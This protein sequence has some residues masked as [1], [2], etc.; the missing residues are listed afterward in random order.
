MVIV[1]LAAAVLAA[2][3]LAG[4]SGA[5][6]PSAPQLPSAAP[7]TPAAATSSTAPTPQG[8]PL[9][10][11]QAARLFAR[12]MGPVNRAMGTFQS[13]A[14]TQPPFRQ[15]QAEGAVVIAA[16]HA[17]EN[18]LGAVRWPGQVQSDISDVMTSFEPEEIACTQAQ[19]ETGS[20]AAA[21][22]VSTTNISC[23]EAST[24][25]SVS[26]IQAILGTPS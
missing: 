2:A 14:T 24:D 5:S 6:A 16:V 8:P 23:T 18:K 1:R 7:L 9:T 20:Y 13:D 17:S 25:E 11:K 15:F 22:N 26:A 19:I 4:C 10:I 3:L 21:Q 12:I